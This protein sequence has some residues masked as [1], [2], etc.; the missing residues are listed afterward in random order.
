MRARRRRLSAGIAPRRVPPALIAAC[1]NEVAE[2][3]LGARPS[4]HCCCR[5]LLLQLHKHGEGATCGSSERDKQEKQTDITLLLSRAGNTKPAQPCSHQQPCTGQGGWDR[6]GAFLELGDAAGHEGTDLHGKGW[7]VLCSVVM[8]WDR[9]GVSQELV[10]AGGVEGS[11]LDGKGWRGLCRAGMGW[12]RAGTFQELG[13]ATG[14]RSGWENLEI[15]V[16][17]L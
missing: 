3:P 14:H 7:R 10:D 2:G 8:G 13:V 15:F 11:D 1:A 9:A 17:C 5:E 6:A 12:E 16:L 4:C